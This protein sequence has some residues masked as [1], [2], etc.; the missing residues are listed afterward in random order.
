MKNDQK[1]MQLALDLAAGARGNTNP[2]PL[3]GAVI[4]KDGIIVG[5]GL[6]RKAGEP[7]AEVHAFH[8]AGEHAIGATL[9]VTLEPCSH[10]GKTPPCANLVKESGVARV[11]IA[12]KDPNPSV[13]GRGIQLLQDAGIEVE[14]G[15]L[16][17]QARR[18]NERFIHNM[19]TNRPFV[20][21]K[22]AMTL[23]GKIATANGHSQWI[24][25]EAARQHVHE[26]RS[27]MDAILVGVGTILTDNPQLTTRLTNR[28]SKNPIR[29][30]LDSKLQTPLSSHVA[31]TTEAKTL[32]VT[33]LE[34]DEKKAKNLSTQGVEIIRVGK[35]ERGLKIEEMLSQLYHRG[36]TDILL[37]GGGMVNASFL[38]AG[39]IDQFIVYISPKLL[40]GEHSISPFRGEDVDS[41]EAAMQL[42]FSDV[43]KIG[44]DL[45]VI[46]YPK[47]GDFYA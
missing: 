30:I 40:G 32:L 4:V 31:N 6:H 25:G 42:N 38:R 36:I 16:E 19:V 18:L 35:D 45:V 12:M 3:V 33:S 46:A 20:V 1:Y 41:M 43:Q 7:H 9:Y 39:L 23:D 14:V 5:T 10:F 11:V 17:Q 21:S 15:L 22:I 26:L 37:E 27:E 44:D 2:N 34:A 8:M 29:I 47:R 28:I 24:T 13:A